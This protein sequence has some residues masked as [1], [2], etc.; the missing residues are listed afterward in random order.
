MSKGS[1]SS[2]PPPA[3]LFRR[4]IEEALNEGVLVGD[5]ALHLTHGDA[6]RLRRDADVPLE[7]ISYSGGAMHFLGV[8][9]VEGG[10]DASVLERAVQA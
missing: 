3:V 4:R 8:R 1:I 2:P 10:I 5:M 9:V 7:A 6:R